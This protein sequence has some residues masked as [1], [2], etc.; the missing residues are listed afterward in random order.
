MDATAYITKVMDDLAYY[1]DPPDLDSKEP[2]AEF[3]ELDNDV[4]L[5]YKG[6][7]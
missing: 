6:I 3:A 7:V 1:F 4:G 5:V 2:D